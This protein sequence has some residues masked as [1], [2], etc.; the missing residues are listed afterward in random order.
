MGNIRTVD[1]DRQK[2]R[3]NIFALAACSSV[4][5]TVLGFSMI[6][7]VSSSEAQEEN[8][9]EQKNYSGKNFGFLKTYKW[10]SYEIVAKSVSNLKIE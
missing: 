2:W 8:Q 3:S 7:L 6:F 5:L 1:S 10:K 4:V 9:H